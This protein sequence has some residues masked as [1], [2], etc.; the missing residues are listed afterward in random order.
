[1]TRSTSLAALLAVS[2]AAGCATGIQLTDAGR[3]VNHITR[4]DMPSGCNLIGDVAIGIPP[5]AAR[6]RTEDELV[7]LMR[8]KAGDLGGNTLLVD[9]REQRED[10]GGRAYFRGRGVAYRCPLPEPTATAS[11]ATGAGEDTSGGDTGGGDTGD[12]GDVSD[13]LGE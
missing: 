9:N 12:D 4:A 2:L 5:D 10:S 13:L 11:A 1:M 8:N 6:P 3:R 7:V